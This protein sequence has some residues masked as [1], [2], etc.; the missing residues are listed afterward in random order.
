MR[1]FPRL[2][3]M[4]TAALLLA[5]NARSGTFVRLRIV[6]Y[7]MNAFIEA[8]LLDDEKPVTVSNFMRLVE[9]GSFSNMFLHR[10]MPG[11]VMQGGGFR[12]NAAGSN[13]EAVPHFGAIT[14]EFGVGP[15]YS[16]VRGTI[17]MA[18]VGGDPDSATS[19]FFI[20][21]ADNSV[22]LDNQ[23]GGFTVF[24]RVLSDPA[25]MIS[26][27][28]SMSYSNGYVD[29]GGSF[30]NLPV[31]YIGT[32]IPAYSQLIYC[33]VSFMQVAVSNSPS[34]HLIS[35]NSAA[36]L[37]NIVEYTEQFSPPAWQPL[38]ETNGTGTRL[39]VT[40]TNSAAARFYRVRVK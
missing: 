7:A 35:W 4:G 40:D 3:L 23:N 12:V 1:L 26:A 16:N 34:G 17:A 27:W 13:I 9:S 14:N 15:F 28:N 21:L 37:T 8:E 5:G 18:K 10:L 33:D 32:N 29:A 39:G 31:N 30:S 38:T 20:N 24:A 19:Q 25:N 11:F 36:G 6:G 2:L 22:N